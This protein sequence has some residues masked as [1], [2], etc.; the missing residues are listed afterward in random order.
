MGQSTLAMQSTLLK[1]P[2]NLVVLLP[3]ALLGQRCS[4]LILKSLLVVFTLLAF[5]QAQDL[6]LDR[7]GQK[8]LFDF[9]HLIGM[10]YNS[11]GNVM[12]SYG[13]AGVILWDAQNYTPITLLESKAA[14]HSA[15]FSPDGFLLATM[16]NDG[17]NLWDVSKRK[18]LLTIPK[19]SWDNL[20]IGNT[21]FLFSPDGSILVILSYADL[22][23]WD[24]ANEQ[25][26]ETDLGRFKRVYSVAFNPDSTLLAIMGR[27]VVELWSTKEGNWELENFL[28]IRDTSELFIK[29]F[30]SFSDNGKLLVLGMTGTDHNSK[31]PDNPRIITDFINVIQIWDVDKH[32]LKTITREHAD[33]IS[34][35]TFNQ[36]I[37]TIALGNSKNIRLWEV[38][39][40]KLKTTLPNPMK[41]NARN[42]HYLSFNPD[43]SNLA[44]SGILIPTIQVWD[45]QRKELIISLKGHGNRFKGLN[46]PTSLAPSRNILAIPGFGH[47][48]D[49]WDT[50][51]GEIMGELQGHNS[52]IQYLDFDSNDTLIS[53]DTKGT[54]KLW[55]I[56]SLQVK[57]TMQVN[58]ID[59]ASSIDLSPDK[60]LLATGRRFNNKAIKLWD[61]KSGELVT[62]LEGYTGGIIGL[63][64]HPNGNILVSNSS[65]G[66]ARLWDVASGQIKTVLKDHFVLDFSP[67]GNMLVIWDKARVIKL[68]DLN[69]EKVITTL[70]EHSDVVCC[71]KFSPDGST[72]A[73]GGKD[74]YVKLWDVASGE[75]ITSLEGSING[76][77]SL[78]FSANGKYLVGSSDD[79]TVRLWNVEQWT[80]NVP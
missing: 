6:D 46:L 8:H 24:V 73:L 52:T 5:T 45:I 56:N 79:G 11:Q 41:E 51:S 27:D 21:S 69:T 47:N 32:E 77:R 71:A 33:S 14:V 38:P 23:L 20:E 63:G 13:S 57:T 43:G 59:G 50:E 80:G 3:K 62:T 74:K 75:I 60:S 22:S 72:L 39:S 15:A 58:I 34:T 16:S 35:F 54:V 76:N 25:F 40:G 44:A 19:L 78:T 65:D 12:A 26:I 53:A 7:A 67:D 70:Q 4:I 64:F 17:V 9:G 66:T 18:L 28:D 29:R 49:L 30:L 10:V 55:D 61:T 36:K 37:N 2:N 42:Y 1:Q 48:I 31:N 68:W